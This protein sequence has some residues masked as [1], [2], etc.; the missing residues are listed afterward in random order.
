MT[1][2]L[3]YHATPT[4]QVTEDTAKKL[5]ECGYECECRGS[6]YVKGKGTLTTYFVKTQFDKVDS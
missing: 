6:T 4:M 3:L 2:I 1:D 5:Q